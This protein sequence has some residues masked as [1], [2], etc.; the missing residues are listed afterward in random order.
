MGNV[1]ESKKNENIKYNTNK[2]TRNIVKLLNIINIPLV[3]IFV[4]LFSVNIKISSAAYTWVYG[5][6]FIGTGNCDESNYIQSDIYTASNCQ[7]I[8]ELPLFDGSYVIPNCSTDGT[9]IT[10]TTYTDANCVNLL[11]TTTQKT[12][13]TAYRGNLGSFELRCSEKLPNYNSAVFQLFNDSYCLQAISPI[14]MGGIGTCNFAFNVLTPTKFTC[15]NTSYATVGF[16]SDLSCAAANDYKTVPVGLCSQVA[17]VY[18]IISTCDVD[19]SRSIE[20]YWWFWVII[21]SGVTVLLG[22]C[23]SFT[24]YVTRNSGYNYQRLQ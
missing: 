3:F 11:N 19:S 18:T 20:T 4:L 21:I 10:I 23:L 1:S 5:S 8:G 6:I 24:Y 12:G 16:F 2:K 15:P 22:A 7:P 13:C 14:L 9:E 17:G